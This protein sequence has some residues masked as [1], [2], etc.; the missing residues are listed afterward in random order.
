M[1]GIRVITKLLKDI[2]LGVHTSEIERATI[3][4]LKYYRLEFL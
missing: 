1:C 2:I 4:M 3:N